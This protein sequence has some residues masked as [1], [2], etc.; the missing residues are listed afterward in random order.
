M[1]CCPVL[2]CF[3]ISSSSSFEFF[4]AKLNSFFYLDRNSTIHQIST[5]QS[6]ICQ[7]WSQSLTQIVTN[8]LLDLWTQTIGAFID[9]PPLFGCIVFTVNFGTWHL[10]LS[11]KLPNDLSLLHLYSPFIS[12]LVNRYFLQH[13]LEGKNDAK[14]LRKCSLAV[15]AGLQLGCRESLSPL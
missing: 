4:D 12:I 15:Y 11:V 2:R 3:T 9:M 13:V 5:A 8:T 14:W 7:H 6:D 1:L 10:F